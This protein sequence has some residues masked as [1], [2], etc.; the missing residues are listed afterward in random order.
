MCL[1]A[2]GKVSANSWYSCAVSSLQ[3]VRS[4]RKNKGIVNW[5]TAPSNEDPFVF[6][7]K[8]SDGCDDIVLPVGTK[9][10]YE[11]PTNNFQFWVNQYV[12]WFRSVF[13][14]R[15]QT[16]QQL[17]K[18][19]SDLWND[20]DG[21]LARLID[22]LYQ[23]SPKTLP[24]DQPKVVWST[25]K[26]LGSYFNP[27]VKDQSQ[28]PVVQLN[29]D[30]FQGSRD[31]D[32]Q[33]DTS[34]NVDN[35]SPSKP[36]CKTGGDSVVPKFIHNTAEVMPPIKVGSGYYDEYTAQYEFPSDRFLEWLLEA[37]FNPSMP[38]KTKNKSYKNYSFALVVSLW[39]KSD[40]VDTLI[41]YAK[42]RIRAEKKGKTKKA[43]R[44]EVASRA[45]FK[46]AVLTAF[47]DAADNPSGSW[48]ED[49]QKAAETYWVKLSTVIPL[50]KKS[51]YGRTEHMN[52]QFRINNLQKTVRIQINNDSDVVWS[53]VL[54][55]LF[56]LSESSDKTSKTMFPLVPSQLIALSDR[57]QGGFLTVYNDDDYITD[58][59]PGLEQEYVIRAIA[60]CLPVIVLQCGVK[61]IIMDLHQMRT[62]EDWM[63]LLF[64]DVEAKDT[65]EVEAEEHVWSFY[66]P[67]PKPAAKSKHKGR[68]PLHEKF[69]S[70]PF[71]VSQYVKQEKSAA[72]D[73]R[74]TTTIK[75]GVTLDNVRQHLLREIPELKAWGIGK[76]VCHYYFKPP[77]KLNNA[78]KLYK[79]FANTKVPHK[80]NNLRKKNPNAHA[81]FAQ[82]LYWREMIS[83]FRVDV[84]DGS[85]DGKCKIACGKVCIDRRCN[86]RRF[87]EVDK[88]P[89]N[90]DHD[91][92]SST[93]TNLLTL[94]GI[95]VL[96]EVSKRNQ[97]SNQIAESEHIDMMPGLSELSETESSS[98]DTEHTQSNKKLANEPVNPDLGNLQVLDTHTDK[99]GRPHIAVLQNGTLYGTLRPHKFAPTSPRTNFDDA[100][101]VLKEEMK[102]PNKKHLSMITDGG[103]DYTCTININCLFLWKLFI[104]YEL[105]SATTLQYA[106]YLSAHNPIEHNW[107]PL[108]EHM[109]NLRLDDCLPGQDKPPHMYHKIPP[110][111]PDCAENRKATVDAATSKTAAKKTRKKKIPCLQSCL[112]TKQA[113]LDALAKDEKEVLVTACH[114]LKDTFSGVKM[115]GF[116]MQTRVVE[117]DRGPSE[118]E[119]DRLLQKY[120]KTSSLAT[121]TKPDLAEIHKTVCL[122]HRHMPVK[123]SHLVH[124]RICG[125]ANC[126]VKQCGKKSIEV[127]RFTMFL[128]NKEGP[129][130]PTIDTKRLRIYHS[131][132]E[133]K[134]QDEGGPSRQDQFDLYVL[135]KYA[136]KGKKKKDKNTEKT[137]KTERIQKR[138]ASTA[139]SVQ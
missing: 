130:S 94:Q 66:K 59:A 39:T 119:E 1:P 35:L 41:Q 85:G 53:D 88:G 54:S 7:D 109:L 24:R 106:A 91:Y 23:Q 89:D 45:V 92:Q 117:D 82:V 78:S 34:T 139:V 6:N 110:C 107:A 128:R 86:I 51:N 58:I 13:P 60:R 112:K 8:N 77:N 111:T 49:L 27:V 50:M 64:L 21:N 131:Y 44:E 97:S 138:R 90:E 25:Q 121:A 115:S 80:K 96:K 46:L 98:L 122:M 56:Q 137:D 126:P 38:T 10:I 127:S 4:R 33:D 15:Q 101:F 124:I 83:E 26:R 63:E 30:S 29:S 72:D 19:A 22:L 105:E 70:I 14:N 17:T 102:D 71:I 61:T 57:I 103:G 99:H 16:K 43:A 31:G 79:G 47:D 62:D 9:P 108:N 116:P 2:T 48:F 20:A 42:P 100:C 52:K 5:Q 28:C 84:I 132:L 118:I 69:S 76:K 37:D 114:T 36:A 18:F 135:E 133:L 40:F 74:R 125:Y 93:Q 120:Y 134:N 3:S 104:D 75:S 65:Q 68:Q 113:E 67:L 55:H 87:F 73:K 136:P 123:S 95:L 32:S 81:V 129:F 12:C 11:Q